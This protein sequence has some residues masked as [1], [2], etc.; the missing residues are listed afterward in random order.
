VSPSPAWG[1]SC[2]LPCSALY[3]GVDNQPEFILGISHKDKNRNVS[4]LHTAC[5]YTHTHTHA[6]A[7]RKRQTDKTERQTDIQTDTE[8]G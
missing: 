4:D 3:L 6:R 1:Y 2:T 5:G 8:K 7:R